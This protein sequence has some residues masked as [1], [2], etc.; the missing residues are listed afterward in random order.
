[1]TEPAHDRV[2]E[3]PD[4]LIGKPVMRPNARRLV[5]GRG[6]Y[7][8]DVTLPRMVHAAFLRSPYAHARIKA[9]DTTAARGMPG[10]THVFTGKDLAGVCKP[11]VGVLNHLKGLKS[12]T[13]YPMAIDRACWQG[14]PVAAVLAASRAEAEDAVERIA[15]DWKVLA[16]FTDP[17]AAAE[18]GSPV[19]HPELGDNIALEM[20]HDFGDWDK[21][22]AEAATVVEHRYT[23]G[24]HTGVTPEPRGILADYNAAEHRL[25]CYHSHQAPHMIQDL[26]A[27]HLGIPSKDVRIV[28]GDVGGA[29]GIKG[30]LYPDEIGTAALSMLAKRPVKFIADRM[31]GFATDIHSRDHIVHAKLAMAGDGTILGYW[32]DDLAGVGPYSMYPR[33]SAVEALQVLNYTG[34]PYKHQTYR[35]RARV[36]FQNKTPMSQYR[37]VGHPVATAVTETLVESAARALGLDPIDVRRRNVIPDDAHPSKG[38]TGIRFEGLS[39]EKS[40][41]RLM[42]MI[43]YGKLRAEQAKLRQRGIW[44]GLG[45]AALIELTNPGAATYGQGGARISSQD[46]A[47]ARLDPSGLVIVQAS[48]TEQGQGSDTVIAQIAASAFGTTMD[49]VRVVTGDTDNVPVGWGAGGSGGAGIAGEAALQAAKA[50]RHN[51]V[52]IAGALLQAD[53]AGLDIRGGSIVDA[54]TGNERM[55]LAEVAR[56]AWFRPDTLPEG[57]QAEPMATRHYV[58]RQYPVA[59]TN[60]FHCAHVE[61]DIETGFVRVLDYWGVEDCGTVINSLL[62]DEQMRGATVTGLGMALFEECRYDR[63]GNLTNATMADYLVP[64]ASEMPDIA[65]GHVS[66][67]TG[68]SELGA[69]GAGEAGTAGAP[70]AVLNAVNDA[71]APLGAVVTST[72]ITPARVLAAL[73]KA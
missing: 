67:P 50:L 14:E 42:A 60:S 62:V 13:Q 52:A 45:F 20:K 23:F 6:R 43:D 70:G 65:V 41:D 55:A 32:L 17:V 25:T 37:A 69:K 57:F 19:M 44:R 5:T 9:I 3:R 64:M 63:D 1:M 58:P 34:G 35:A 28:C 68:E 31:E 11:W 15:V 54:A 2:L 66:T 48:I 40:I 10:V 24:R 47:A 33:T 22:V 59:F 4:S 27:R 18:P 7:A 53:P 26:F 29:Y 16:P 49:R 51:V 12:G 36:V 71:L 30:H 8:D 21:A 39:H 61:V 73:G 56:I 72:P 46:G 38:I